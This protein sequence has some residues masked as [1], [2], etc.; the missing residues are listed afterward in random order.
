MQCL[1]NNSAAAFP[2]P[3]VVPAPEGAW[4]W[5]SLGSLAAELARVQC[6]EELLPHILRGSLRVL[7]GDIAAMSLYDSCSHRYRLMG[8]ASADARWSEWRSLVCRLPPEFAAAPQAASGVLVLPDDDPHH[9]FAALLTRA[10]SAAVYV[11]LHHDDRVFGTLHVVRPAK[12][13]F[14]AGDRR[15]ARGI[16]DHAAL[17]LTTVRVV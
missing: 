8:V 14:G 12:L 3:F 17:A 5:T 10:T 11:A 13:P 9:P 1:S 7:R 16:G 6:S 4:A 2:P 15:Q